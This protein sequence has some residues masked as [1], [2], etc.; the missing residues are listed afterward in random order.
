MK[1]GIVG[2]GSIGSTL[3]EL[4]V[5]AGHEVT[6]SNSRGPA[7]LAEFVDGLG[8]DAHA[9]T[10]EEAA[11]FGEVVVEAIPFGAYEDLPAGELAGTIVVSASNYY[12]NRDGE[13]DLRGGT[14]TELVA[15]HLADARVVKAFNTM[16]WETL[17][18]EGRPDAPLEDRL[19]LFLAG[20]DHEAK[21]V[22]NDLIEGIGFA[23][24]DTGSLAEG[25][26]RQEP[27]SP[28]YND[29]M[30]PDEARERLAEFEE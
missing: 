5:A 27:G 12:P 9:S 24:V 10:V 3:A 19:V 16:Y 29:P 26:H 11:A 8:P 1:I 20:D 25:G 2:S 6:I 28:I 4:F 18:D 14:Q 15:D 21:A 13:I 22:V 23:P 17:R 30:T 7:S